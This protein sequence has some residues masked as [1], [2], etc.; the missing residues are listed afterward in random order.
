MNNETQD[1]NNG[2]FEYRLREVSNEEIISILRYREHFN[3]HAVKAAIKEAFKR[4]IISDI[5][6]LDNEEFQP[7][8]LA[9]KSLFP[10]SYLDKQNYIVFRSL[11]RIFYGMGLLPII[12]GILQISKHF[13]FN[14]I[15][16]ILTGLIIIVI[17]NRLEKTFKPFFANLLLALNLPAIGFAVYYLTSIGNPS[18]MDTFAVAIVILILLYTTFYVNKLSSHFNK[19]ND[20]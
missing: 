10:I 17:A 13:S 12:Y 15:G 8:E 14:A 18:T 11:C 1:K 9:P 6:D 19:K 2:N 5:K 7:Q 4:G 20:D 3:P 16:A